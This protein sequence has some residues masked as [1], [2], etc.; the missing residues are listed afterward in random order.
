MKIIGGTNFP[1]VPGIPG[2]PGRPGRPER[3]KIDAKCPVC[4][5]LYDF[6]RLEVI[7][8]EDGATLMYIK[9][10]TCHSA[11]LSIIALGSF[12][13]KVASVITDLEK[14]EVMRFQEEHSVQSEDVLELHE[15]LAKTDNF[16]EK[17]E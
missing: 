9:C 10:S 7:Q 3:I 14:D 12:G 1:G 11:A 2:K 16:L 15:M 6:G 13:I 8:E 5:S 4:N 17:I